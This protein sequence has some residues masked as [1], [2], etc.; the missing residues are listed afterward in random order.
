MRLDKY[1]KVAR[2]LKRRTISKELAA[3][4]RVI[5]NGKTAKPSYEVKLN[6]EIEVIFGR[7]HLKVR[8]LAI[9]EVVRKNDADILY[10]VIDE[11]MDEE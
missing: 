8:V 4:E 7:R 6:D 10:E 1:L 2:I 9:K 5:V 11:W 3:N